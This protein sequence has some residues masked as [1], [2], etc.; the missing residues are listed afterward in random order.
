MTYLMSDIHGCYDKFMKMLE[1]INFRS[2]DDLYILGDV[3]DRGEDGIKI[4]RYIM[5]KDN[6]QLLCGNHEYSALMILGNYLKNK[7]IMNS[8]E[9]KE[10][11][12][13][14]ISDGGKTTWDGFLKLTDDEQIQFIDFLKSLKFYRV[15]H[16]NNRK[17]FLSHTLPEK[18]G[19]RKLSDLSYIDLIMGEPDYDLRYS[20]IAIM[21][22]GHTPTYLI[23]ERLDGKIYA[24]NGHLAI[25]C[26]A[27]FRGTLSCICLDNLKEFYVK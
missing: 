16:V 25:D 22:T 11:Y 26:G 3:L 12:D 7:D 1:K 15:L 10:V 9:F 21:V 17:Y 5:D 14:W 27:V 4:I 6:I 13:L 19:I 23:D 2:D 20:K 8:P 18:S 24:Q